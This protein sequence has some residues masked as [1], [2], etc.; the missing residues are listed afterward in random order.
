MAKESRNLGVDDCLLQL[1]EKIKTRNVFQM[2]YQLFRDQYIWQPDVNQILLKQRH[3]LS[4]LFKEKCV[5][6]KAKKRFTLESA[7]LVAK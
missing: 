2:R 3:Y 1:V 5:L 7:N 4:H 6:H